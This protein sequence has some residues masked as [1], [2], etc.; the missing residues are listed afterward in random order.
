MTDQGRESLGSRAGRKLSDI[1]VPEKRSSNWEATEPSTPSS[2][3]SI[4]GRNTEYAENQRR[5]PH[6]SGRSYQMLS[7]SQDAVSCYQ[8]SRAERHAPTRADAS[9]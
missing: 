2:G 1:I 3:D 7:G 5:Q 8:A 4:Y 6:V 9:Y